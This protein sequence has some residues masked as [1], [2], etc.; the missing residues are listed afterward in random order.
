[1]IESNFFRR[2]CQYGAVP[3]VFAGEANPPWGSA[4]ACSRGPTFTFVDL[5]VLASC[6]EFSEGTGVPHAGGAPTSLLTGGG[7]CQCGTIFAPSPRVLDALCS[8]FPHATGNLLLNVFIPA[9]H[10]MIEARHIEA[11]HGQVPSEAIALLVPGTHGRSIYVA[12]YL[13]DRIIDSQ[14]GLGNAD[15]R[16]LLSNVAHAMVESL[17]NPNGFWFDDQKHKDF[18]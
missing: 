5:F 3:F 10:R 2:A 7:A 12:Y 1:L 13:L 14:S 4:S 9:D 18:G 17:T 8:G 15:I 16:N 11:G 6:L